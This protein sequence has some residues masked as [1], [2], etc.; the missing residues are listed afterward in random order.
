M[1]FVEVRHDSNLNG[2]WEGLQC[3]DEVKGLRAEAQQVKELLAE[4]LQENRLLKKSVIGDG[5]SDT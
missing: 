2:V 3:S 1:N 4:V 5:E